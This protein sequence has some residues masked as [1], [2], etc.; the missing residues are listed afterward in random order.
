MK[1]DEVRVFYISICR[2]DLIGYVVG[3][4]FLVANPWTGW[5]RVGSEQKDITLELVIGL[6][7][8]NCLGFAY[9]C[10]ALAAPG[11]VCAKILI[12]GVVL[13]ATAV[14]IIP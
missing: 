6:T 10:H 12:V 3:M 14:L 2:W 5:I 1:A 13:L 9:W 8:I 11:V 7:G 4:A